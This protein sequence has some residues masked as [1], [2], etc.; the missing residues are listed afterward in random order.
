MCFFLTLMTSPW[1]KALFVSNQEVL[2]SLLDINNKP[3][4]VVF[5]CRRGRNPDDMSSSN[6][7]NNGLIHKCLLT[8]GLPFLSNTHSLVQSLSLA[9]LTPPPWVPQRAQKD[10]S[11]WQTKA[12]DPSHDPSQALFHH[13][14]DGQTLCLSVSLSVLMCKCE[15]VGVFLSACVC[16]SSSLNVSVCVRVRGSVCNRNFKWCKLCA[17]QQ[18][19]TFKH[20][21][22]HSLS[23][24]FS[25]SLTLLL[26]HTL[27]LFHLFYQSTAFLS[28]AVFKIL[29]NSLTHIQ[30]H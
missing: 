3:L 28:F 8:P 15:C 21:W 10:I 7:I 9:L 14:T 11:S 24:S 25:F 19:L 1:V 4:D 5:S 20:S 2:F 26:L 13:K 16:K 6:P 23:H 12:H 30:I 27:S 18:T 17:S 22:S 29:S